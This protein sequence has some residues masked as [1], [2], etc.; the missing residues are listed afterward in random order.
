MRGEPIILISQ[1]VAIKVSPKN[2]EK[3][4]NDLLNMY[5]KSSVEDKI[6]L[7]KLMRQRIEETLRKE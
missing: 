1:Y 2:F 3:R 7:K 6:A 4:F 5:N